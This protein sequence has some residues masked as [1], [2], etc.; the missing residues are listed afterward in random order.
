MLVLTMRPNETVVIETP[1]GERVIVR[2]VSTLGSAGRIGFEASKDIRI[3]RQEVYDR[4]YQELG[5]EG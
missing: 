2:L 4:I 5:G 1:S 3:H